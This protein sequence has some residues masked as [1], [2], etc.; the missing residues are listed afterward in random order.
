MSIVSYDPVTRVNG[1]VYPYWDGEHPD[2]PVSDW[3]GEVAKGNTRRGYW[4]W[5]KDR[6]EEE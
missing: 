3:Q 2:H 4:E 6:E 5:V 1:R